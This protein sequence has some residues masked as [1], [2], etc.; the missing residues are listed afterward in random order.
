MFQETFCTL[1]T[2]EMGSSCLKYRLHYPATDL[3]QLT[4][5]L[6]ILKCEEGVCLASVASTASTTDA[7]DVVLHACR[8]G[9]DQA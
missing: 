7:V 1:L 5:M 4:G 8:C 2:V 6:A 9:K 3:A